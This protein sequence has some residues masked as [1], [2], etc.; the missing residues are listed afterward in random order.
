MKSGDKFSVFKTQNL[1]L[2]NGVV[3]SVEKT[4]WT[5]RPVYAILYAGGIFYLVSLNGDWYMEVAQHSFVV[6]NPLGKVV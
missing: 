4:R 5:R 6:P 2:E 3:F 1:E